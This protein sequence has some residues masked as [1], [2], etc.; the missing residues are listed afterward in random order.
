MASL[1]KSFSWQTGQQLT[2]G[3]AG[4]L[5]ASVLA[6]SVGEKGLGLLDSSFAMVN[7][8]AGCAG[9]G[10][11]RIVTRELCKKD[12]NVEVIKGTSLILSFGACVIGAVVAN[13][14]VWTASPIERAVV[15]AATLLLLVQ[16]FGFLVSSAFESEG[17]LD[18]VGKVLLGGLVVS[19]CARISL[20]LLGA[21]LPWLALAYSIDMAV[22]C[23]AGWIV[24]CVT[25]RWWRRGWMFKLETAQSLLKD[26]L[27]LLLSGITAY[28]YGSMDMIMLKYLAGFEE[29]GL[30]GAAARISQI[31]LFI[32]AVLVGVFTSRLMASYNK[33]GRF[34]DD[35]LS[36]I[37]KILGFLSI[38][39]LVGG[40]LL[41]PWGV[42]L[43]YGS[44]FERSGDVLRIHV[45]GVFFMVIGFLRNHL[46]ILKGRGRLILIGDISGATASLALNLM[47]IPRYGAMGAAWSTAISYFIAFFAINFIHPELRKYNNL[48][49]FIFRKIQK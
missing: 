10:M 49:L 42:R 7:L 22:S 15:A 8:I 32:P 12:H 40:W 2:R 41:G 33:T 25:V 45:V 20:A 21:D 4:M 48:F 27:P 37:M 38:S 17:R 18:L 34:H 31:P 23:T 5:V 29:T 14:I 16:P 19:A 46:L 28:I 26:S 44:G 6:R 11:Q 1:I 47:L 35:D 9:L 24:A 13:T 43:V 3:I 39:V 36:V 30:Y